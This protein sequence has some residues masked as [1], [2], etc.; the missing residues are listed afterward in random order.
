MMEENYINNIHKKNSDN[1]NNNEKIEK[2]LNNISYIVQNFLIS[3]NQFINDLQNNT[4]ILNKHIVSSNTLLKEIKIDKKYTMKLQQLNGRL[5]MLEDTR[6]LI[7]ENI[8]L[9]NYNLSY[10]SNDIKKSLRIMNE[11]IMNINREN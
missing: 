4:S 2:F 7:K 8:K 11:Y 1:F 5:W 9:I 10:F 6:K 3:I